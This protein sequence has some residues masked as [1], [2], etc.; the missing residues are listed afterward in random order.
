[1]KLESRITDADRVL[2]RKTDMGALLE[3]ARA[4]L[5][6][7]S[8]VRADLRWS[9]SLLEH[10][11]NTLS[12]ENTTPLDI[13]WWGDASTDFGIGVVI[14]PFWGVWK[15]AAPGLVG[16]KTGFSIGWAEAAAVL[17]GLCMLIHERVLKDH[18][19]SQRNLLVRSDNAAVVWIINKGRASHI[20]A[21]SWTLNHLTTPHQ[22]SASILESIGDVSLAK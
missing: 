15:W 21:F 18:P 3:S 13:G 6:P 19:P 20:A 12:L 2:S 10:C 8:S 17:M 11:R 4:H 14:G 5:H 1:M 7:P 9:F 16:P 22:Q